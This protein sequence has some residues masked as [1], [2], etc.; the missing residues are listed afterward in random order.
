[1]QARLKLS[2][3][4]IIV[5]FFYCCYAVAGSKIKN[6]CDKFNN[7]ISTNSIKH[8]G[9]GNRGHLVAAGKAINFEAYVR[10]YICAHLSN[11]CSNTA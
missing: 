2:S 11:H 1:M 10:N 5:F 3:S 6:G 7:V 8:A 9:H 4:L